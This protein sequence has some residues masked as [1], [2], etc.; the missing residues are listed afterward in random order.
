MAVCRTLSMDTE[1]PV[2]AFGKKNTK[3][4]DAFVVTNTNSKKDKT[5]VIDI[6]GA[7]AKKF[8]AF[9]TT[10]DEKNLYQEIGIFEVTDGRIIYEAPN[11]SVTTF[12]AQ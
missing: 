11:G 5:V 2:L 1:I 3:N 6:V 4:Q 7:T 10:E 8:K 12:F 9:R